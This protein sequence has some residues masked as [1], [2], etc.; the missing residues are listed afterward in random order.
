MN[1]PS[2]HEGVWRPSPLA[3][4]AVRDQDS[5]GRRH[6]EPE[7]PYRGP[8][9]RDRDRILYSTAFRRLLYKTQV[10]V[11]HEGDHNRTRLTHTL[12][13]AQI[14]RTLARAL[15]LNEDLCEAVALGHDLGH[16]PFGHAGERALAVCMADCGGFEHNQHTLRVVEV[17]EEPYPAFAGLNLSWE[18]C[19]SVAKHSSDPSSAHV[20]PYEPALSPT[21][22]AQVVGAADSIAYD[23]HDLED[24]LASGLVAE[25]D[26]A[27]VV[28]W[29]EAAER[30]RTKHGTTEG[31]TRRST[32]VRELINLL[33]TDVLTET[34]GTLGRLRI[35][36]VGDVR[37]AGE[38]LVEHSPAVAGRK[39]ELEQFLSAKVYR[40]YRVARMVAKSQRFVTELFD[41]YRDYP[42]Q[43]PTRFLARADSDGLA[44]SVCDYVAGM[45]DRYALDEYLR[46]FAPYERV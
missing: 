34:R 18:V 28:L 41:A 14:A 7:H 17:L 30:G 21:L 24:S 23:T 46:L 31:A 15:H 8:Y 26:L 10:F 33:V 27:E 4:Y 19:E 42:D 25:E 29:S 11:N 35:D 16:P 12:E 13:V 1:G 43:L 5:R 45:T 20:A 38:T 39:S 3:P 32:T 40:H 37:T 2:V 6:P 9:A 22:E 36:S 44:R